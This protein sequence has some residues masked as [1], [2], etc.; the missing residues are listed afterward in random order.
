MSKTAER[1]KAIAG[2]GRDG[3]PARDPIPVPQEVKKKVEAA[4][5]AIVG[6]EARWQEALAFFN[7][8]QYVFVSAVDGSL[9]RLETREGGAKPRY[10]NRLTRNRMTMQVVEHASFLAGR[11]PV[12][13]ATS[14]NQDPHR[15]AQ[16]RLTEQAL[17]AE[18]E[19]LALDRV[20]I[21]TLFLSILT[22]AG[23]TWPYWDPTEGQWIGEHE[24]TDLY[25]GGIKFWKLHQGE[26]LWADGVPF[27]ESPWVCVRKAQSVEHIKS[28]YGYIGPERLSA[29]AKAGLWERPGN[30]R[31]EMAFV[32]NW[33]ERPC[34]EKPKGE[35][36][37]FAGGHQIRERADYPRESGECCVH[38]LPW[39]P[40]PSRHRDLGAGEMLVDVQRTWNRTLNQIIAWKNLVLLPQM[41]AP[42]GSIQTE[43][44][45]EYGVVWQYRP[46]AGKEPEW[47]EVPEIPMSLFKMLDLCL[48]DFNH[49]LG[50]KDLPPGLESGSG[51]QEFR[52]MQSSAQDLFVTGMARW[53]ASQGYHLA[54]LIAANY[55][56]PRLLEVQ[57]RFGVDRIPDFTGTKLGKPGRIK[58]SPASVEPRTRDYMERRLL[59]YAERGWLEPHQVMAAINGGTA[60][61]LIDSYELDVARQYREIEQLLAIGGSKPDPYFERAL[62]V[63]TLSGGQID[64][65]PPHLQAAAPTLPM[66]E[67]YDNHVIHIDVLEQWMKTTEFENQP[68]LVKQAARNHRSQHEM[69]QDEAAAKQMARQYRRAEMLGI[70][71]AGRDPGTKAAPSPAGNAPGQAPQ[72]AGQ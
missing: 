28:R 3:A 20:C 50:M 47:R 10:R 5:G 35:W 13:Q 12:Y 14:P 57:G 42:V 63:Y 71:N 31:G 9:D 48:E 65:L 38:K 27:E 70:G 43:P 11:P 16:A 26:V 62:D 72:P 64:Q 32:Y 53:W 7:N 30:R 21:D 2:R 55:T 56:E 46:I 51:L 4:E 54:E 34:K 59:G 58:V 68:E 25:L 41:K 15:I 37:T 61:Q 60:A 23:F 52:A 45:D 18:H 24:D 17:L 44:T 33:L 1:I 22:G 29:D 19:A 66:A 67:D 6:D 49:I 69:L 39:I 40:Q 8:D 36:L